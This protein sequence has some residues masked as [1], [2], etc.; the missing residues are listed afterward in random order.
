MRV[1]LKVVPAASRDE[2]SDWPGD[3]LK[4]RPRSPAETGKVNVAVIRLLSTLLSVPRT[5][6]RIVSG[7][8]LSR[9]ILEIDAPGEAAF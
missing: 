5:S 2:L 9:K 1:Q 8:S 3:S 7:I 4:L 6:L